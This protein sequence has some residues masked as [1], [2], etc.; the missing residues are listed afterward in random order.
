MATNT[1]TVRADAEIADAL[2]ELMSDGGTRSSVVRAAIL[3]AARKHR[4][5]RL[6]AEAERLAADPEDAAEMRA[7]RE[8]MES[9]RAW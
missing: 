5:A 4:R 7:V 9:L 6:R 8:D 2:D 1:I 3:A